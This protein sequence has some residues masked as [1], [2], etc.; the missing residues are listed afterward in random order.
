ME[1]IDAKDKATINHKM[2]NLTAFLL[3]TLILNGT[4]R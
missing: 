1:K 3:Q 2:I 4:K